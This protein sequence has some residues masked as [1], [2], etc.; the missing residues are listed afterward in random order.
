MVHLVTFL[1]ISGIISFHA[2]I[3]LCFRSLRGFGLSLNTIFLSNFQRKKSRGVKSGN[4][5]GHSTAYG[6]YPSVWKMFIKPLLHRYSIACRV[7]LHLGHLVYIEKSFCIYSY[8]VLPILL[9][10]SLFK[11]RK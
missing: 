3:I 7:S 6:G 9:A 8:A 5:A 1:H 4:L 10:C 11:H 2:I